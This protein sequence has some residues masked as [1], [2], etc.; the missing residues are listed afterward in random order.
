[1]PCALQEESGL[2]SIP[3]HTHLFHVHLF[4][5]FGST[6]VMIWKNIVVWNNYTLLLSFF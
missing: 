5:R 1:M 2:L 4:N 6:V 3:A